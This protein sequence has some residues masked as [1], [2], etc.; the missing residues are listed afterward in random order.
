M[1]S[2]LKNQFLIAMPQLQDMNFSHTLTYICEHNE[3]GAMGI[4]INRPLDITVSDIFKHLSMPEHKTRFDQRPVFIGGPVQ[5][6]RGFVIHKSSSQWESSLQVSDNI[7][8]TTSA[9]ILNAMAHNEGPAESLIALGYA[10]WGAGQLEE[11]MAENSWLSSPANSDIIFNT[12]SD[13][14]WE[15]AAALIGIDLNLISTDAGHA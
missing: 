11:E 4:V 12:P 9:D 7:Q 1:G 8:L 6:E 2:S 13:H 14:R 5:T 3:Y 15:A 10:G